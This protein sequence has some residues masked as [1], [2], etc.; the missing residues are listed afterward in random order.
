MPT[1]GIA[2]IIRKF[3][4]MKVPLKNGRGL[5]RRLSMAD[6]FNYNM[7][8]LLQQQPVSVHCGCLLI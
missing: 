5:L 2:Q 7:V 6:K 1:I 4:D 3:M 8:I